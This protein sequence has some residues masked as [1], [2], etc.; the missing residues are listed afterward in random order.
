MHITCVIT[1]FITGT[2]R[3]HLGVASNHLLTLMPDGIVLFVLYPSHFYGLTGEGKSK[4]PI[5]VRKSGFRLP[6]DPA[7]PM[8]MVGPGTGLAP[9]RGF[10]Q[11]LYGRFPSPEG[12]QRGEAVLFFGC[13]NRQHDFLYREELNKAVDDTYLSELVVAF[14]REQVPVVLYSKHGLTFFFFFLQGT[15]SLCAR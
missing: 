12:V 3:H 11:E 2:G 13:R 14:S 1:T 5:F 10:I 7:T 6:K 9:F 4:I 15:K 8:I